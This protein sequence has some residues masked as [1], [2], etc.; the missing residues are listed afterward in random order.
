ML[1]FLPVCFFVCPEGF[2]VKRDF[3]RSRSR[4]RIV[5]G[6]TTLVELLSVSVFVVFLFLF[7]CEDLWS[8]QGLLMVVLSELLPRL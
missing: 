5:F 1:E 4:S 8:W 7:A 6:K 3:R 2:A